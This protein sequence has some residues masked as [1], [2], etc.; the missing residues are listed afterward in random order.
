MTRRFG[1]AMLAAVCGGAALFFAVR[2]TNAPSPH[3]P[4]RTERTQFEEKL[5]QT[6]KALGWRDAEEYRMAE[7]MYPDFALSALDYVQATHDRDA[8]PPARSR[9][10]TGTATPIGDWEFVGPRDLDEPFRLWFGVGPA[11]GRINNAQW[12]ANDD[13]IYVAGP[14]GAFVTQDGGASWNS[15]GDGWPTSQCSVLAVDWTNPTRMFAGTGDYHSHNMISY[16]I[17]RTT[18]TP[19]F[20]WN[21]TPEQAGDG[22]ITDMEVLPWDPQ[23]VIA[24]SG[25]KYNFAGR[26]YRSANGGMTWSIPTNAANGQPLPLGNWSD[27]VFTTGR[28][29]N[30]H[31]IYAA[32]VGHQQGLQI[33]KSEDDGAT[34]TRL[35]G[36][37]AG[38]SEQVRLA[39]SPTNADRLYCMVAG[40]SIWR[41]DDGGGSWTNITGDFS[42]SWWAQT[43]YNDAIEVVHNG[44]TGGEALVVGETGL[45]MCANPLDNEGN[46]WTDIAQIWTEGPPGSKYTGSPALFH[47]DI[48]ALARNPRS[49]HRFLVGSDGGVYAL[50]IEAG[51]KLTLANL[52]R[53]LPIT[54]FY[55]ASFHPTNPNVMIGGTQDNSTP[56]T[57]TQAKMGWTFD[58]DNVGAGDGGMA[59]IDPTN[60]S[61]QYLSWQYGALLRTNDNWTGF[62]PNDHT[63]WNIRALQPSPSSCIFVAPMTLNPN[64]TK[65]LYYVGGRS[66]H[67]WDNVAGTWTMNLMK[68]PSGEN[69]RTIH[70]PVG[71]PNRVYMGTFDGKLWAYDLA[72]NQTQLLTNSAT[73]DRTIT[74]IS[75]HPSDL[76]SIL[77]TYS[78]VGDQGHVFR[79]T[80]TGGTVGS[81]SVGW[82]R[83][84]GAPYAKLPDIPTNTIERDPASPQTTW[85]V[86]SD[87]GVMMTTDAGAT[88]KNATR[89]LGLPNVEVSHLEFVPSTGFLNCATFGR[90][91][92]RLRIGPSSLIWF[93]LPNPGRPQRGGRRFHLNLN[94]N[95]PAPAGGVR[96]ALSAFGYGRDGSLEPT[97]LVSLPSEVGF[98][99]G[100]TATEIPVDAAEVGGNTPILLQARLGVETLQT[101][102][103]LVQ[104]DFSVLVEPSRAVGG[105][106]ATGRVFLES[107]AT[108][109]TR[110]SLESSDRSTA[111]VPEFVDIP[112]GQDEATFPVN[113]SSVLEDRAVTLTAR[114]DGTARTCALTVVALRVASIEFT[115][116]SVFGGGEATGRVYLTAPSPGERSIDLSSDSAALDV[117]ARLS[118]TPGQS[119]IPFTALARPVSSAVTANVTARMGGGEATAA[120]QVIPLSVR[121]SV[122]YS[123]VP[124]M[125]DPTRPIEVRFRE[126]GTTTTFETLEV[127]PG[128]DGGFALRAPRETAFDVAVKASHWL[129][130]TA[131]WDPSVP[132]RELSFL[133]VNGDVNGDNTVNIADF[134][135]LRMAFGSSRGS[136]TWNPMADLNEDGSVGIAD[137]LILRRNLGSSGE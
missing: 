135:G 103:D 100:Q 37:P 77:I 70:I 131:R 48:H 53:A 51:G 12:G 16:G 7:R 34:F 84:D 39:T 119:S 79:G 87:V 82:E 102:V 76:Q 29:S 61:T 58:W 69:V 120:I 89:P 68:T 41:T 65:H 62:N 67:R 38:S 81:L 66:L 59:F 56:S 75:V 137:F 104:G 19:G 92:Y 73:P 111:A 1:F 4:F 20:W 47:T 96:V 93:N 122:S 64:V 31:E 133:L 88:W 112:A 49:P 10:R 74:D 54:Q 114:K 6:A 35:V 22:A 106:S 91:I 24:T 134:L 94:L 72:T 15:L 124:L 27:L 108:S 40:K 121:G 128:P 83:R 109:L 23:V 32:L 123:D 127:T 18:N 28:S 115:G 3:L 117:P 113:T 107:P 63:P 14:G 105:T 126:P 110:V 86:G 97:D 36:T 11:S 2:A 130:R 52:N 136:A 90:G 17:M 118:V 26:V 30:R 98:G 50:T 71:A 45:Y 42:T 8:L 43:G 9:D 116:P 80:I 5:H 60:P 132:E 44:P 78:G 13:T 25:K 85:Y 21:A 33:W 55:H 46:A 99:E 125:W 129:R 101:Q 95:G 57:S